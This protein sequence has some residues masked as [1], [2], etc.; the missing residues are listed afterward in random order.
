MPVLIKHYVLKELKYLPGASRS[1]DRHS[2][3]SFNVF[4]DLVANNSIHTE[5]LPSTPHC[6]ISGN[7]EIDFIVHQNEK[8][9]RSIQGC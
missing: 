5:A 9:E 8:R 7:A 1:F 4:S 6:E 2:V 3:S